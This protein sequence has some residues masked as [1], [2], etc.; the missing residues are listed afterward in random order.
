M[1]LKPKG[2]DRV[3]IIQAGR[4]VATGTVAELRSSGPRRYWVDAPA[5]DGEWSARVEGVKVVQHQG[6]RTLVELA[7][8]TDDQAVLRAAL[9]GGP[10][11]EFRRDIPSLTELFRHVVAE[12]RSA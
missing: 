8:S 11:H 2:F 5:A 6:S 10:V 7:G 3:G 9:S 12:T 1:Y 4:M